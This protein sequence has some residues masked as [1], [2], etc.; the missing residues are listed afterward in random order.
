MGTYGYAAPEYIMTGSVYA[1]VYSSLEFLCLLSFWVMEWPKEV[2]F[3]TGLVQLDIADRCNLCFL[4][5]EVPL[6]VAV[7]KIFLKWSV[8]TKNN[9]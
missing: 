5:F 1:C 8:E 6:E 7:K 2:Q 4:K 9:M 3:C